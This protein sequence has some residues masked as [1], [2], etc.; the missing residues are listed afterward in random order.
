MTYIFF[1]F[2][3]LF[4]TLK[5]QTQIIRATTCDVHELIGYL[6]FDRTLVTFHSQ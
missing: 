6:I 4:N 2:W 3:T 1:L 5:S